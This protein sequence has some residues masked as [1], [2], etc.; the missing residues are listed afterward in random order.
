M[1]K[2]EKN[3]NKVR[4]I[5]AGPYDELLDDAA[6]MVSWIIRY[7]K[8]ED[9]ATILIATYELCQEDTYLQQRWDETE[10]M[11]EDSRRQI[12]NEE[13]YNDN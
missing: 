11:F 9:I 6:G 10:V 3:G 1:V 4:V 13:F 12:W 7:I 5:C 8:P 2:V